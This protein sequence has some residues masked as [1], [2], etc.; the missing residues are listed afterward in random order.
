MLKSRFGSLK[1]IRI[2]VSKREDFARV[3]KWIKVCIILYN[4]LRSFDDEWDDEEEEEED[5]P[6]AQEPGTFYGFN[7]R[8]RVQSRLLDWYLNYA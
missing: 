8:Q 5:E 1:G 7:L 2:Q 4:M 6:V 3:N